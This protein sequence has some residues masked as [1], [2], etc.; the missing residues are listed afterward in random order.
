MPRRIRA[1]AGGLVY[2]VLNRGVGRMRLFRKAADFAAMEQVLEEAVQRTRTRLLAY[3]L[4]SNHWHLLLWPREDGELS[5]VM[6]WLTVTHT[7]RWHANR[8][9]EGNPLRAGMVEHAADWQWCSLWRRCQGD[10]AIL[11]DWPIPVPSRWSQFVEQPQTEAELEAIRRS[12]ARGRPFGDDR[13]ARRIAKRFSLES[14]FRP[15]GRPRK[16]PAPR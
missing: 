3:C 9:V 15:Q 6:R 5:E 8:H 11:S 12:V 16:K 7:R 2:H 1:T 14:T 4:M 13:W 10:A